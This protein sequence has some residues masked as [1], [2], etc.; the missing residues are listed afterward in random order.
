M[1]KM[2]MDEFYEC[3]TQTE[4]D[5]FKSYKDRV[6]A[7]IDYKDLAPEC[8]SHY[9]GLGSVKDTCLSSSP[10]SSGSSLSSSRRAKR[11]S[12]R[13]SISPR[14][15]PRMLLPTIALRMP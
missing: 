13:E 5:F 11:I 2:E 12:C 4:A 9:K 7:Q 8:M 14:R 6:F 10:G 15:C 3:L 1:T